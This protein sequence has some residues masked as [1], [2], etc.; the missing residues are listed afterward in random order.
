LFYAPKIWHSR[1]ISV[2]KEPVKRVLENFEKGLSLG[3]LRIGNLF[4][5]STGT[6]EIRRAIAINV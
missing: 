2:T 4:V 3:D 1:A 5:A 6:A